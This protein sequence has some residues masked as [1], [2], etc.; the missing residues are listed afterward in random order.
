[1]DASTAEF[2]RGR[3]RVLRQ[4]N[5]DPAEIGKL[6]IML[7]Y[8]ANTNTVPTL[9]W[10][11]TYVFSR[12]GLLE[13]LHE[14][15]EPLA[16][17]H[18]NGSG[19]AV[20]VDLSDIEGR[21]PQLVACYRETLRL[22]NHQTSARRVVRDTVLSDGRGNS[23][24]LKAGVDV[25]ISIATSHMAE[26][27]WGPDSDEFDPDRFLEGAADGAKARRQAYQPFGGGHHLCPGRN[28]AFVEI[29]AVVMTLI[30]GYDVDSPDGKPWKIPKWADWSL[31]DSI[32]KPSNDGTGLGV[33]MSK[34]SGWEDVT[35]KYKM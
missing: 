21:C 11:V 10:L 35:W 30:L 19:Q 6:E 17:R 31:V 15:V 23:Y 8:A 28:F 3:A 4:F 13:R 5:M 2:V 16:S 34:K 12:P 20:V 14:E 22:T 24:L 7:P 18:G 25:H 9:F 33:V 27:V 29:M 1:M 32:N 26:D